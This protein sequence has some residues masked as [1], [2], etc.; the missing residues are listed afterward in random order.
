MFADMD[1]VSVMSSSRYTGVVGDNAA[2]LDSNEQGDSNEPQDDE[3]EPVEPTKVDW[4]R[5]SAKR[6]ER[7]MGG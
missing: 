5:L 4:E 1:D 6:E 3:E 2:A 7:R